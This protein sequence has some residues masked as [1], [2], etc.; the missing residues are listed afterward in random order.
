MVIVCFL[1]GRC[2]ASK[3]KVSCHGALLEAGGADPQRWVPVTLP[4]GPAEVEPSCIPLPPALPWLAVAEVSASG[5]SSSG[6]SHTQQQLPQHIPDSA[7]KSKESS[8][9]KALRRTLASLLE[10]MNLTFKVGARLLFEIGS[11]FFLVA[12]KVGRSSYWVLRCLV[13]DKS[14][15]QGRCV[16]LHFPPRPQT[17]ATVFA[18]C[19]DCTMSVHTVSWRTTA[20]GVITSSTPLPKFSGAA[21]SGRAT[22]KTAGKAP[23]KA[24]PTSEPP[25][26]STSESDS[27]GQN[28]DGTLRL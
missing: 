1:A 15:G 18:D 3:T 28:G 19:A 22:A 14:E 21:A 26:H 9:A 20:C 10:T 13:R 16:E 17:W 11:D 8:M 24:A 6:T 4:V 5:S 23:R 7:V 2:P 12:K 27:E 25:E